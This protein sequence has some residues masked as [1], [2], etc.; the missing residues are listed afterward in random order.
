MRD[1][2]YSNDGK[3]RAIREGAL[4]NNKTLFTV[5]Y[6]WETSNYRGYDEVLEEHEIKLYKWAQGLHGNAPSG[7]PYGYFRA[8]KTGKRIIV[9]V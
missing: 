6:P 8:S 7:T 5:Y 3:T 2:Y 9:R 1:V 4:G